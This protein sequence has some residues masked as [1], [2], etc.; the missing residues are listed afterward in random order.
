MKKIITM[1]ICLMFIL[2]STALK[3]DLYLT[4]NDAQLSNGN[5]H[6]ALIF[7]GKGQII[8]TLADGTLADADSLYV[9]DTVMDSEGNTYVAMSLRDQT[10][11]F[12]LSLIHI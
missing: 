3:D 9:Q 10:A 12:D 8:T 4:E 7:Q 6:D 5:A 1:S 2:V 11:I